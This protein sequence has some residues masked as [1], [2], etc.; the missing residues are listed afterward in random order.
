MNGVAWELN[1]RGDLQFLRQ[2]LSQREKRRLIVENGW[3]YFLHGWTQVIAEVLGVKM[4]AATFGRL[5]AI[6]E[7]MRPGAPQAEVTSRDG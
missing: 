5:A 3:V 4:D 6:A 7:R 2:A 1:Y